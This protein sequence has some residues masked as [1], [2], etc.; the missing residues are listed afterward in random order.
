MPIIWGLAN[1][2]IGERE[3]TQALLEAD[4]HPVRPGQVILGG[5]GFAG[6]H[7]E[8]FVREELGAQ[9]IRPDRKDEPVRFGKMGRARQWIEAVFDT[10]RANSHSK[11]TARA[12]RSV[13]T[14]V[15]RRGCWPW[16]PRSGTTGAATS[17]SSAH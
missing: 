2:K 5:K 8:A 10:S 12:A 13:C 14:P 3:V 11:S 17:P 16:P 4:R 7:V 6:R 9:L 1:P 15:S